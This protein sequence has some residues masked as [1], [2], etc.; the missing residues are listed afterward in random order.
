MDAPTLARYFAITP[1]TYFQ[2]FLGT[3]GGVLL[4]ILAARHTVAPG[5]SDRFLSVMVLGT[6]LVIMSY[7]FVLP[8]AY[9]WR[10]RSR[11]SFWILL[12]VWVYVAVTL[13][14]AAG[15]A[16]DLR[17]LAPL[18][19]TLPLFFLGHLVL[20]LTSLPPELLRAQYALRSGDRVA[21]RGLLERLFA[22]QPDCT[23]AFLVRAELEYQE[24]RTA[25]ALDLYGS[26]I[27]LDPY[28][29]AVH[30]A[31]GSLHYSEGDFE[32]ARQSY[33][34]AL[35]CQPGLGIHHYHLG[36]ALRMT[37]CL[38]EALDH[39]RWAIEYGLKPELSCFAYY[40]SGQM[41]ERLDATAA[42]E[43]YYRRAT[44]LATRS[45]VDFWKSIISRSRLVHR[46]DLRRFLSLVVGQK[47][48]EPPPAEEDVL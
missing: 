20:S 46:V 32:D 1:R 21:C 30:G 39:L 22:R 18:M 42:V 11:R 16:F 10:L 40:A 28:N 3:V 48:I 7:R 14:L 2:L 35:E 47:D 6:A 29:A 4:L 37:A 34:R 24:D 36:L 17:V 38:W 25:Q 19:L 41:L 45:V 43:R 12:I 31:L 8:F 23:E 44:Q 13:G 33:V 15:S 27:R 5:L 9:A 26:A